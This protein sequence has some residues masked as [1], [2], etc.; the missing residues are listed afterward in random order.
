LRNV[1]VWLFIAVIT[2]DLAQDPTL[3]SSA[4]QICFS[5]AVR[6]TATGCAGTVK[7]SNGQEGLSILDTLNENKIYTAESFIN[8]VKSYQFI[9]ELKVKVNPK[10]QTPY[11]FCK[12]DIIKLGKSATITTFGCEGNVFWNNGEEGRSKEVGRLK[13]FT[14]IARYINEFGCSAEPI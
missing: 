8:G 12:Y 3:K 5:E 11:L 9:T 4:T 13:T 1:L 6:L 2:N 7:W 14:Y 10:P